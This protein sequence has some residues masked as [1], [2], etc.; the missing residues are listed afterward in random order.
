MHISPCS[1]S[2]NSGSH[3]QPQMYD[4][5]HHVDQQFAIRL[6]KLE[7]P[8]FNGEPL[9]WHPFW[10]CF[11]A[12][13]HTNPSL[14]NVQR[15]TYLRSKV[16]GE[17]ARVISSHIQA[18]VDLPKPSNKLSSLRL[19]H[20]T[21]ESHICCLES[22]G[23]SPEALDTLLVQTVLNKLPEETKRN[24]ARNQQNVEWIIQELQS[25]LRNEIGL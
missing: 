8:L 14:T 9:E 17:A 24:M 13:I 4:P 21:V 16:K 6:P 11:E 18:L 23:M 10:D 3:T 20:D 12:A 19:F 2:S 5:T 1:N 25:A 7:L 15:L 22:L